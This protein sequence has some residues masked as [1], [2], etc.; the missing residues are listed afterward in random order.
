VSYGSEN[1]PYGA[2][3]QQGAQPPVPGKVQAIAIMT[4]VGGIIAS[5]TGL[6]LL[7]GLGL[8]CIGLLWPGTYYSIVLGIMAIIKG[9]K[10][11]GRNA[12]MEPPPKTI[13]IMQIINIVNCDVPN[14]V[15]GIITLVFL[16]DPDVKAY[17]RIP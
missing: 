16:G 7:I 3:T 5:L 12:A 6:G 1:P 15:M 13:A 10:L 4:L 14:C 2:P 11:L 8:T 9:S 17:F